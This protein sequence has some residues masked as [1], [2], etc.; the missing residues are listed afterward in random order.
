MQ[1]AILQGARVIVTSS[2]D[3]KLDRARSLGASETINYRSTP[4]WAS[5]V[6]ALTDGRGADLVV[7]TAGSLNEPIA[8]VR[9]GGTIA[10]IGLLGETTSRVD[11]VALMG[12]SARIQAI[13]VGSR[14]MFESMNRAIETG[15]MR[16]VVDRIF[17]FAEAREAIGELAAGNKFGKICVQL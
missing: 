5:R 6:R 9:I 14:A 1:F 7:D 15:G 4:D 8:A 12:K 13:D 17:P 2:S 11:L 3:A 16:P 10:F